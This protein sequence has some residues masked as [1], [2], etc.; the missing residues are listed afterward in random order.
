MGERYVGSHHRRLK[1]FGLRARVARRGL[2][3]LPAA[4]AEAAQRD[5]AMSLRI[6]EDGRILCAA[7][8][9]EQSG[10]TYLHDGISYRL[11]VELRAIVTEPMLSDR[12]RG[13]HSK[14]GE[15]WWVNA[16]PADVVLEPR[17]PTET[18]E[19]GGRA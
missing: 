13:G 19:S 7:M 11:T 9:P 8:H 2:L 15:W 1:V 17:P 5:E 6:R 12:G 16:V 14:H 4:R 18:R 10:D 3:L